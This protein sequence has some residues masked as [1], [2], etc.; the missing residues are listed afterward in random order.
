MKYINKDLML[1]GSPQ[2]EYVPSEIE[3]L[4]LRLWLQNRSLLPRKKKTRNILIT[5]N[6]YD[7]QGLSR[8]S[9]EIFARSRK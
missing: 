8:T 6:L 9:I 5:E 3:T 1:V 4:R 7:Y 2:L